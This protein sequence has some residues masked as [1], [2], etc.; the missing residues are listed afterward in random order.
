MN[1]KRISAI[2][3]SLAITVCTAATGMLPL[4]M[5]ASAK[6]AEIAELVVTPNHD[7]IFCNDGYWRT[8]GFVYEFEP[9]DFDASVTYTDGTETYYES[10][11]TLLNEQ[12]FRA[13]VRTNGYY[14]NENQKMVVEEWDVGQHTVTLFK[15]GQTDNILAEVEINI[16]ESN[17]ESFTLNATKTAFY[18]NTNLTDVCGYDVYSLNLDWI[19]SV[20]VNY[21]DGSIETMPIYLLEERPGQAGEDASRQWIVQDENIGGAKLNV[22]L[23]GQIANPWVYDTE[24]PENNVHQLEYRMQGVSCFQEI[25]ILENPYESIDFS[26]TKP[27]RMI[28]NTNGGWSTFWDEEANQSIY[29]FYYYPVYDNLKIVMHGK[30]GTDTVFDTT[31]PEGREAF[32]RLVQEYQLLFFQ[33]KPLQI[34]EQAFDVSIFGHDGKLP[35]EIIENPVAGIT[36]ENTAPLLNPADKNCYTGDS[37]LMYSSNVLD[38]LYFTVNFTDGTTREHVSY[39]ELREYEE[40]LGAVST[41]KNNFWDMQRNLNG[42]KPGNTYNLTFELFDFTVDYQ[43]EITEATETTTEPIE[44]TT[45]EVSETTTTE[46]IETTTTETNITTTSETAET[47]ASTDTTTTQTEKQPAETTT[48][49]GGKLPQTGYSDWYDLLLFGAFAL[50]G[51]GVAAITKSGILRK[52]EQ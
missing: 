37:F 39:Q 27:L 2:A 50:T 8:D 25:T 31:E 30:D 23:S 7:F 40:S 17:I 16:V 22:M 35:V 12:G 52:K 9:S 15:N 20:T 45:T 44:T 51:C 34:G 21:R 28:E 18:E 32:Y 11:Q 5:Y 14:N 26:Y 49:T 46:A 6:A 29:F 1:F 48:T 19:P 36:L 33:E 4:S 10:L 42:F 24:T 47:T 38:D 3:S 43:L 41:W 13:T